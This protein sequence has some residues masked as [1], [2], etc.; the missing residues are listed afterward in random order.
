MLLTLFHFLAVSHF[1]FKEKNNTLFSGN[2]D[3]EKN[4]HPGGRKVIFF[5]HFN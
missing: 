3:D 5:N 2:A 4:L 1:S